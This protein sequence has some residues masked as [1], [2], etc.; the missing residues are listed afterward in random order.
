MTATRG[1]TNEN[2]CMYVG[3]YTETGY[4]YH[5]E[6]YFAMDEQEQV[7]VVSDGIGGAP[8]GDYFSRASCN[9]F[10]RYWRETKEELVYDSVEERLKEVIVRTNSY[11]SDQNDLIGNPGS[12]CTLLAAAFGDG[13]LSVGSVGDSRAYLLRDNSLHPLSGAGRRDSTSN[14]L[15]YA[16]GYR[17][18]PSPVMSTHRLQKDDVV[19]LCTDGVW[20]KQDNLAEQLN[21]EGVQPSKRLAND[22][23][24]LVVEAS[25]GSDNATAV[26]L[27]AGSTDFAPQEVTPMADESMHCALLRGIP[28]V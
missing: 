16:I 25:D 2:L 23:A 1:S 22:L 4:R 21:P 13:F 26:V 20:E 7:Y 17:S 11:L 9:L 5:N 15:D 12:G 28:Q 10:L 6:D 24:H 27:V 8:C 18:N 3:G 19:V 14:R